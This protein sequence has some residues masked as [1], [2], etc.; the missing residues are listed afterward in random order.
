MMKNIVNIVSLCIFFQAVLSQDVVDICN[1]VLGT[2]PIS[3]LKS[4]FI[5]NDSGGTLQ[6]ASGEI[7]INTVL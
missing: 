1:S 4:S 3:Y 2:P 7:V 5:Q 6:I